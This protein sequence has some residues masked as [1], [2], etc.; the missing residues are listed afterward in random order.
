MSLL[1]AALAFGAFAFTIPLIIH[2][3]FRSRFKTVDWG[4]MYLLESVV[5]VNRR[6]M[7]VTNL[8][9]LL[10]RC[11]IPVLLAFCLARPVWTGLRALAGDAPKTLVIAIDDS[12]SLS[13]TPPGEPARIEVAKQEIRAVLAELTRRDEVMLVRGSRLGAVP[14]KMGVSDALATLRKIDAQGNAVSIGQLI[15]AAIAAADEGSH[16]RRQILVVSDF[17]AAAVDTA[18]LEAARRIA[19]T[20]KIEAETDGGD[21]LVIDMLD[22]GTHWDDLANVSVDAVTIDSPVIVSERSGVYT[23]TLR[24]ASDLPANDLRLIWSID[25]K[26][27]E[28]RVVSIDAKS[29]STNR[30]TH[31]IDQAGIHEVAATIDRGDVLVDDNSR[32]VAVEV[33]DEVNVLLVDGRPSNESLGGQADFLAIALS[34]FAFG[35]DD[36]PD[37]VRAA[38]VT[39]KRLQSALDENQ[40]RV[41]VLC[42]VGQL[43][44]SAKQRI[45][46]FVDQGGA[47]VVF[48]GPSLRPELYN[49][50]WRNQDTA[51]SFPASLG[52]IVGQPDVDSSASQETFAIDQPTSLYQPWKILARGSDNPLSAVNVSAYRALTI[53]AADESE[54]TGRIVLLRTT[55]GA[56][57]AVMD[58]VGD[59]TVVQFAISGNAA[60]TNL[61]LR[62]VFLPLIQQLVLDLAGKRSDAMIQVGQPIVIGPNQWPAMKSEPGTRT[63]T[64]FAA[65]TPRGQFE[66]E[67]PDAGDPVRLT[68][69]YAPG[70]YR[71]QKR[72]TDLADPENSEIMETLRIATV[73]ASES[74]LVDVSQERQQTLANILN[75]KIFESA[76]LL[77]DA[78]RSRSFGR[79]IW[80]VIL[81]LLLIALV[82]ELW[83]QQN[84]VARRKITGGTP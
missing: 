21:Q 25:G 82:A 51:L 80:R 17:Q 74:M 39:P 23:A 36:R 31:T 43:P 32:S 7:Q 71:I 72:V 6:R 83:L 44:D 27:L 37:P 66:L 40:T 84:L 50:T 19:E 3:F 55:D 61:P 58:T 33:I 79:E 28:P 2:L 68:A 10:L 41:I 78:D 57:L 15:D 60:W 46:T 1:N 20:N 38:V 54:S 63:R 56:P 5:R 14:S 45:A 11:A 73:D 29:T 9:L 16:P 12:R 81:V 67:T 4:A 8:L 69:T 59:G 65:R 48:D 52:D 30:L 26:P 64:R 75:A 18:T 49:Q 70:V 42:G 62:P 24:N 77:Q 53:D 34:P 35:G 22:V 47:L 13:L 76:A